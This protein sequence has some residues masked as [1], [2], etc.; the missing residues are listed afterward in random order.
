MALIN[1]T[2][3]RQYFKNRNP[4]GEELNLGAGDKPDWWRIVGVIGDVK[5]FG[6]DQRI[7]AEI[8][9][10]FDQQ[11][12]PVIAFTL[13][14][15][16]DS[17]ATVKA[18]ERAL[19]S[20]DPDLPVF[21]AISMDV[22]ASQTLAVRRASS[23]LIAGFALLALVLACIGIYGAMAYAVAQRTPE[24]GLRMA[25]GAQRADVLRMVMGLS[26]RLTLA[27][28]AIGLAGALA[29]TQLLTSLLFEVSA[30][31]PL[32]FSSTAVFLIAVAILASYLPA[33]RAA[34]ID[35]IRALR[36]E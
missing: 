19:W 35:P 6:Q 31:N 30:M 12:Y 20:V 2:L 29:S 25:L 23:V 10:P 14:T 5:G 13:L 4:V 36:T 7:H 24:I 26:F 28:V 34:S 8:Y 11:P 1:Q 16:S 3:A 18:A 22:L 17:A 15:G 21:R 33:R 9:R 27:G 32:I